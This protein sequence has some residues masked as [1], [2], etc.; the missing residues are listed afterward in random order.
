MFKDKLSSNKNITK[1]SFLINPFEGPYEGGDCSCRAPLQHPVEPIF[2]GERLLACW[3]YLGDFLRLALRLGMFKEWQSHT[4]NQPWGSPQSPRNK[5][6][7][8]PYL[9]ELAVRQ[10]P[11]RVE[12]G[13]GSSKSAGC[14]SHLRT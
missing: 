9:W 5:P 8:P 12:G 4:P 13:A 10:F 7:L 2:I 11:E 6:L 3:C 1:N 14:L